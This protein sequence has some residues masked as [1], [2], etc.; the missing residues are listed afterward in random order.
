MQFQEFHPLARF[1]RL[2]WGREF[3]F[4]Q[5][6]S[7]FLRHNPHRLGKADVL[8]FAD[9]AEDVARRLAAKAVIELPYRMDGK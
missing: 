5:R 9:E 1:G 7:A 2:L 6:N 4:R 3:P 8:N